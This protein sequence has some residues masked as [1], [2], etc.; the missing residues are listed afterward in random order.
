[1]MGPIGIYFGGAD[2]QT[3]KELLKGIQ[4]IL[5]SRVD[6]K[7][8]R[9]ALIVLG[10]GVSAPSNN[11]I[12]NCHLQMSNPEPQMEVGGVDEDD[13]FPEPVVPEGEVPY[14]V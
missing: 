11:M 6:N 10:K 5:Q 1:M 9:A 13:D 4:M 7:T 2:P 3:V 12:S 14:G 8:M